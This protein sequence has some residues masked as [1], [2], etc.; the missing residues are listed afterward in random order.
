MG[1]TPEEG[2]VKV[3]YWPGCVSRGLHA[4]AARLDGAGR[5]AARDRA[6]RARPRQ[7]LRR[8][9]DRR[10]QPGAGRHAQ[11][12]HVRDG[13]EDGPRDDEHL[14]D[15]PGRAVGVP[16]AARRRLRATA[17][18]STRSLA[19]RGARSTRP[20]SPTRTSCG[21]WSRTT[22]S[23]SSMTQVKRP[24]A[25]LR[26]GPF[27][28]CYVLRPTTPAR[29]RG[30]PRAR[31]LPRVGDR[32]AGRRR[33]STT[34]AR[35][36]AAASPSIT[37]NRE[38]S[39]RQAGRH[40]GD[41]IDAGR[42]RARDALPAVPPEPRPPAARRRQGRRPRPRPAGAAPAPARRARAR[43]SSP[44]SWG[45]ASTSCARPASSASCRP[46]RP[47]P[48]PRD[49]PAARRLLAARRQRTLRRRRTAAAGAARPPEAQRRRTGATAEELA[50]RLDAD[51]RAAAARDPAAGRRTGHGG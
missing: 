29:L 38:T 23:T 37:M 49:A 34:T 1:E 21:C 4:R 43:A 25:G 3:A 5:G 51:A 47:R 31:P 46:P 28:G 30:A 36:S 44:R 20:A 22:G 40:I 24:L 14:L 35:A 13:A 15:L 19:R 45:W 11:R 10:A 16:G 2:N 9:R 12:A 6:G 41:A 8:R 32:G 33:R 50:R 27:Y 26:V 17:P 18:T 7:L 48:E 39:L 42:R